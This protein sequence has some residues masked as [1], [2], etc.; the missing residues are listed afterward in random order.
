M[1]WTA[2]SSQKT[3]ETHKAGGGHGVFFHF[4]LEGLRGKARNEDG[5]ITWGRLTE[6]VTKRVDQETPK[7][8]GDDSI[9]QTPNL[10]ANLP[11]ISPVLV[12]APSTPRP[13]GI[14][15]AAGSPESENKMGVMYAEGRA[16][17]KDEAEAVKWFRKAANRGYA[18]AQKNLGLMYE[19]GRG[20]AKEEIEALK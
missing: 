9:N 5:E 12:P 13:V 16:I 6:Y 20:V 3:Y 7:L 4:L 11:G 2:C 14:T 18:A 17:N 19:E 1:P 15:S 10:V 8:L